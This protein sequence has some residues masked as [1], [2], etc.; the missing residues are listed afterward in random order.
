M[1]RIAHDKKLDKK[2]MCPGDYFDLMGGVGF[3]AY[4][5]ISLYTVLKSSIKLILSSYI[6]FM[7]GALRM[8]VKDAMKELHAVGS[9]LRMDESNE[10]LSPKERLDILKEEI[11]EVLRRK[12]VPVDIELQDERFSSLPCKVQVSLQ[13]CSCT[14]APF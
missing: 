11:K 14:S 6:A 1:S 4:V 5:F 3:G 2:T 10:L 8:T 9:K 12:D 7:L 13:A